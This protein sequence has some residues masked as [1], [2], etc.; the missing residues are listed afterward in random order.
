MRDI[1]FG[2]TIYNENS[3]NS[4]DDGYNAANDYGYFFTG[5]SYKFYASKYSNLFLKKLRILQ[6]V[7]LSIL[8]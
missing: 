6:E 8:L 7:Q 4:F 2:A 5:N 1:S 3:L